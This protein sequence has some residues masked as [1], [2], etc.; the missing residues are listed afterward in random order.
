LLNLTARFM[1]ESG[2][3]LSTAADN[4]ERTNLEDLVPWN[5]SNS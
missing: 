4:V 2:L 3:T 1:S 5:L